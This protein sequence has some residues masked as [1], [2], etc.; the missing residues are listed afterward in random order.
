MVCA[1]CPATHDGEEDV[2]ERI[3]ERSEYA[4]PNQT[5]RIKIRDGRDWTTPTLSYCEISESG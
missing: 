5:L 1:I 3:Q 2:G 4:Y